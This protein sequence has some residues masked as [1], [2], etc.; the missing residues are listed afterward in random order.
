MTKTEIRKLKIG[1]KYTYDHPLWGYVETR[2]VKFI[3]RDNKRKPMVVFY[4]V[5]YGKRNDYEQLLSP[6]YKILKP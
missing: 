3:A 2:T 6:R 1:S 5:V 4:G